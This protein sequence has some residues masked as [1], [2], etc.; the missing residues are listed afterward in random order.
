MAQPLYILPVA[1]VFTEVDVDSIPLAFIQEGSLCSI[2]PSPHLDNE[3]REEVAEILKSL[4]S[5]P[6]VSCANA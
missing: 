5:N 1:E 6:E 3:K 4:S 2:L